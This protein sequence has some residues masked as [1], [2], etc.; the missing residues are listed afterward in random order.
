[1]LSGISEKNIPLTYLEKKR[2]NSDSKLQIIFQILF[3]VD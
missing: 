3:H 2:V 1:M